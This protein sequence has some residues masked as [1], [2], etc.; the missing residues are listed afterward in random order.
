MATKLT[1][2][3][4]LRNRRIDPLMKVAGLN[5]AYARL[6]NEDSAVQYTISAMQPIDPAYTAN[7]IEERN[8][9][10]KQLGDGYK[11]LGLRIEFDY[12]GSVT[13]DTHIRAHSDVDLLTVEQRFI[14]VQPPA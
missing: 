7:T 8:R 9:V 11:G 2:L 4:K 1:R 13:N 3:E 10:E 5:E 12:Q 14:G 6:T